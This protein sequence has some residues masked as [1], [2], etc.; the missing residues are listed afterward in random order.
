MTLKLL[1]GIMFAA[2]T[3][4]SIIADDEEGGKTKKN[5]SIKRKRANIQRTRSTS[6]KRKIIKENPSRIFL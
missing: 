3:V 5:M 4:P 2:L 6:M 1:I